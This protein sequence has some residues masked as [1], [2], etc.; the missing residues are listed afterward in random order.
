MLQALLDR[1]PFRRGKSATGT[2]TPATVTPNPWAGQIVRAEPFI[3]HKPLARVFEP[4]RLGNTYRTLGGDLVTFDSVSNPNSSYETMA[5]EHGKHKYTNRD[6]GRCTGTRGY[7][8]SLNVP[9][10]INLAALADY[11]DRSVPMNTSAYDFVCQLIDLAAPGT[12]FDEFVAGIR[13]PIV[14]PPYDPEEDTDE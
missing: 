10:L 5:C 1:L 6:W 4:Y 3:H 12:S 2:V 14:R 7:S 9:P 8:D 11:F 13:N